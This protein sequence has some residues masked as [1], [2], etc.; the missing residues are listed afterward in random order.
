MGPGVQAHH[1][2][3]DG[4]YLC[5]D[6]NT[7]CSDLQKK[8]NTALINSN[9][10]SVDKAY[11]GQCLSL[12]RGKV[13]QVVPGLL[14]VAKREIKPLFPLLFPLLVGFADCGL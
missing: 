7:K 4:I 6:N 2:Q 3:K 10:C 5:K 12:C 13:G 8:T 14:E 11:F 1:N 9:V